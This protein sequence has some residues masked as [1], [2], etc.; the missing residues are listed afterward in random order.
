MN[1]EQVLRAIR[2]IR[3]DLQVVLMSG[4][5]EHDVTERYQDLAATHF[6]QKPFTPQ[7]MLELTRQAFD[8]LDG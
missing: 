2:D 5:N 7:Q 4:Y 1:G 6:L 3:P 8:N